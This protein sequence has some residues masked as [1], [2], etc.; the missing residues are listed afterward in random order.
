MEHSYFRNCE[1]F[2]ILR[3]MKRAKIS[4]KDLITFYL[5]CVR[6]VAEYGCPV[7]HDSLPQYLVSK[8][9]EML[10]KQYI[11]VYRIQE[12]SVK[13]VLLLCLVTNYIVYY[14][15]RTSLIIT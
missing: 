2:V 15:V 14:Q 7:F 1:D 11:Q 10:K 3:Q 8:D 13:L 9:L 5:T 12:L 6:P 4:P